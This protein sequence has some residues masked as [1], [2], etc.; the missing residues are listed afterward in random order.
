MTLSLLIA[1]GGAVGSTLRYLSDQVVARR[2]ARC[3]AGSRWRSLPWATFVINVCGS[4]VLGAVTGAAHAGS[5]T[6][7]SKLILGVGIC[8]G[9]TT[10]S[11][12]M[13]DT[14]RLVEERRL[15]Q[16]ALNVI[17]TLVVCAMAAAIGW[18]LNS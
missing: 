1:L 4:L 8:G 17:A 15:F 3:G 6:A 18:Q 13:V 9:Y 12:H 11:T 16:A 5:I 2:T 14:L 10:F 7:S